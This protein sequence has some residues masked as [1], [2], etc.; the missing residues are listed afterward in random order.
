MTAIRRVTLFLIL[1]A[2]LSACTQ[3]RGIE[4]WQGT[5]TELRYEWTADAGMDV[6]TGPA[7]PVR[8]F[9]ESFMLS[10]NAG[11]MAYAYPGFERAVPDNGSDLWVTRPALDVPSKTPSVGTV[12]HHLLSMDRTGDEV[13]TVVCTYNYRVATETEDG[14]YRSVA[15]VGPKNERGID[16]AK[17]A[18]VGPR[19]EPGPPQSGPRPD[20]VDDVFGE[21]RVR[22]ML[23]YWTVGD[24]GF[25]DAWPTYEADKQKC[26]DNAPDP[27]PVRAEIID[28]THP[29]DF[30]P[31]QPPIPGWPEAASG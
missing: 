23:N 22:G 26:V 31:T 6:R 2:V 8:A 29:R 28:G 18:L 15:R 12:T 9:V 30:F 7:V 21:W 4:R 25:A 27:A 20:P 5:N 17:I 16:V 19:S 10:Q 13:T 11:D 14:S 24:P 1:V 3:D